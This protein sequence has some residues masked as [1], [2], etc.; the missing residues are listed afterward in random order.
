MPHLTDEQILRALAGRGCRELGAHLRSCGACRAGVREW[1]ELLGLVGEAEREP[2]S[3]SE[4]RQLNAMFRELGPTCRRTVWPATLLTAQ[5]AAQVPAGTRGWTGF[6]V[7]E[8]VSAKYRVRMEVGPLAPGLS[9]VHGEVTACEA[10]ASRPTH[11]VFHGRPDV[12]LTAAVDEYG[13]FHFAPVPEGAFGMSILVSGGEVRLPE[14]D[15]GGADA[16]SPL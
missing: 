2:L 9:F 1:H 13:E 10:H 3:A 4:T 11:A 6:R 14:V 5:G 16:D 8:Y 15:A 7:L 12:I